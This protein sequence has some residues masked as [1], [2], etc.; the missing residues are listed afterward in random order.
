MEH[1]F[2]KYISPV[3]NGYL[4]GSLQH[5]ASSDVSN[6]TTAVRFLYNIVFKRFS[7]DMTILLHLR[8]STILFSQNYYWECSNHKSFE[9][10]F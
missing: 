10:F 8:F 4:V 2:G 5:H 1:I 9:V 6:S 3:L 7:I